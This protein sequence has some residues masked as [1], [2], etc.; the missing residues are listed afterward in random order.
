MVT[1]KEII[2]IAINCESHDS[3]GE[4]GCRRGNFTIA[5][6]S[7]LLVALLIGYLHLIMF[8]SDSPGQL[9]AYFDCKYLVNDDRSVN[10]NI[11]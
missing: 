4:E 1:V 3:Y 9:H 8:H 6:K 11:S 2:T 10:K 7:K 5:I